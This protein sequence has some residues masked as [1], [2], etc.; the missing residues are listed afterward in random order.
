MDL[1]RF[2]RACNR[3]SR[4]LRQQKGFTLVEVLVAL[5]IV[6]LALAAGTRAVGAL[7]QDAERQERVLLGQICA[8]NSLNQILLTGRFPDLGVREA[9]C[10]QGG[11]TFV[12]ATEAQTTPNP[13][14][15]RVDANV[16]DGDGAVV[17]LTTIFGNL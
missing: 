7:W 14:F 6:G 5:A 1:D 13:N 9:R 10:E 12:V 15:R 17:R 8:A 4:P 2:V 11:R 3:I 16:S